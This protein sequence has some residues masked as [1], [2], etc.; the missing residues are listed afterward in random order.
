MVKGLEKTKA[1]PSDVATAIIQGIEEGD[2]D[3]Y[4]LGA[5][6]TFKAW[7]ADQKTVEAKFAEIC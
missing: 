6:D 5:A 1:L 7:Q 3:S 2:E 4:P